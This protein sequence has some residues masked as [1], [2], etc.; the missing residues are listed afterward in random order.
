MNPNEA[1]VTHYS[2][3][4]ERDA[5]ADN[6]RLRQDD[7]ADKV[8][9]RLAAMETGRYE[10]VAITEHDRDVLIGTWRAART[11]ADAQTARAD[12]AERELAEFRAA[13][14]LPEDERDKW[15]D[16]RTAYRELRAHH[17]AHHADRDRLAAENAALTAALRKCEWVWY[18]DSYF[19][20]ICQGN[21]DY[22]GHA[23]DCELR[24]ALAAARGEGA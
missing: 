7:D 2:P 24:N 8:R 18:D 4:A 14:H 9:A 17:K 20:P 10:D 3:Q 21:K 1:Q 23:L 16:A 12:A 5:L 19:C 11:E 13:Q 6:G 22:T 15:T